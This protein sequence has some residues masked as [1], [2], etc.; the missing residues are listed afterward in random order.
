MTENETQLQ[1]LYPM[2]RRHAKMVGAV[3][4]GVLLASILVAALIPSQYDA[5]TTL[6]VEP[7]TIS[8]KLVEGGLESDDI[9]SRLHL[10]TMQIL[11]RDRL[12]RVIDEFKLYSDMADE[13]TREEIIEHMRAEIRVEPIIPEFEKERGGRFEGEINTI[14]LWFRHRS[15]KLAAEV[16]N[17]LAGDFID[18]HIRA[19]VQVSGDTAEFMEA[20][21]E[22]LATRARE[23][24]SRIAQVKA[25]NTGRLPED[26]ASNQ[27]M[28]EDTMLNLRM[29]RR[30]L[31]EAQSE[32]VFYR[33]Q[34][35][36]AGAANIDPV[37]P[38]RRLTVLELDLA[39]MRGRGLTDK[40]PD[41]VYTLAEIEEVKGQIDDAAKGNKPMSADKLV[42]AAGLG[43][44]QSKIAEAQAEI[45]RLG[46]LAA[47]I[48]GR[49]GATP[50]IAEQLAALEQESENLGLSL[51]SYSGKRLDATVASN[52]ER[53]QKG[54]Q[55]RV[56]E[57]AFAPPNATSPNRPAI[58]LLGAIFGL[59]LGIGL[60]VLRELTD[61]SYHAARPLQ[62]SLRI[63][64]LASIP[65][66]LLE[67]DRA[68]RR[69]RSVREAVTATAV[70]A[71]MLVL[72]AAGY[73]YVNMPGLW[74][75][76]PSAVSETPAATPPAASSAT[77]LPEAP[78]AAAPD[79][80]P[81]V[82]A[83]AGQ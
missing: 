65:A 35:R 50:R 21:F 11:S 44:A 80:P 62:S 16:A 17:R 22:R 61:S 24:E 77:G 39:A 26:F 10:M 68:A 46:T 75:S 34:A 47:D 45:E 42:A 20:E 59:S 69:R 58:M 53:R 9:N 51:K 1:N 27:R 64:V 48:E 82:T 43:K 5:Y 72:S 49:L 3:A 37:T 70:A 18:E 60:A 71:T 54:E 36:G 31:A 79:A 30:D 74:R 73:V 6:L 28:L 83:P 32:E 33:E 55:F 13:M 63:P 2:V 81:D 67:A 8:K 29:A 76:E 4:G 7:Q 41:V 52:M 14:M 23:I 12:S 40:H 57:R 25:E 66:I 56:L 19:R 15:P 78:P 38:E